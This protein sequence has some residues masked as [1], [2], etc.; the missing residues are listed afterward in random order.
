MQWEAIA[1]KSYAQQPSLPRLPTAQLMNQAPDRHWRVMNQGECV[2]HCS[3]WWSTLSQQRGCIGHYYAATD[4]LAQ[5]L[6]EQATQDLADQGCRE[7]IAPIDGTTWHSYRAVWHRGTAPPFFL[8]PDTPDAWLGQFQA[9]GF[10][11]SQFYES[12]I[13]PAYIFPDPR[14]IPIR[15]RLQQMGIQYRHPDLAQPEV[16]LERIYTLAVQRFQHQP[17]YQAIALPDFLALYRPLLPHLTADLILLAE[18]H[19]QL[20]GVAFALPDRLAP[21]PRAVILKTLVTLSHRC[22]AGLGAVLLEDL[23]GIA[24]RLGYAQVIHALMHRSSRSHNLSQR[25]AQPLRQYV[26]FQKPLVSLL[27][28]Q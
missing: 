21:T 18:H 12:A 23:H 20:V 19:E 28:P 17:F 22:Y 2:A 24:H 10:R 9:A 25:Y 26:L 8:E 16:E 4:A 11:P 6:L 7:A 3:L 15:Q 27:H 1:P 5:Q 14:L 13:A